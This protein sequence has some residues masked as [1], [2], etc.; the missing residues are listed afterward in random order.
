MLL[1]LGGEVEGAVWVSGGLCTV[2]RARA[3]V[4]SY[5]GVSG[6]VDGGEGGVE[7]GTHADAE[8]G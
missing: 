7:G 4:W 6:L 3:A 8:G 5:G 1:A 2:T